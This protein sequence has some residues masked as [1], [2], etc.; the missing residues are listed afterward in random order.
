[1]FIDVRKNKKEKCPVEIRVNENTIEYSKGN[2]EDHNHKTPYH[3]IIQRE[4]IKIETSKKENKGESTKEITRKCYNYDSTIRK[5]TIS[6]NIRKEKGE[7]KKIYNV[8]DIEFSDKEK[9]H[10]VYYDE[11]LVLFCDKRMIVPLE[12]SNMLFIDSTYK[13]VPKPLF[14]Q[15]FSLHFLEEGG[16]FPAIY[17]LMKRKSNKMYKKLFIKIKECLNVDIL[18]KNCFLLGDFEVTGMRFI[19]K[20]ISRKCCYFHFTQNLWRKAQK[21]SKAEYEKHSSFYYLTKSLM[22]FP[23]I[24]KT[25]IND[26]IKYLNQKHKSNIEKELLE[27]FIKNYINGKYKIDFWHIR[28]L[29]IRTNNNMESYHSMLNRMVRVPHPHISELIKH[30]NEIIENEFITYFDVVKKGNSPRSKKQHIQNET[31]IS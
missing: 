25:R 3:N 24:D 29:L 4:K 5:S 20:N 9:T 10:L 12:R 17:C 21:L 31:A 6:K 7:K 11:D 22:I 1:M 23:F 13:V 30:L 27:F 18:N 15:F 28:D 2:L 26:A 16:V 14:Y 19:G 8:N